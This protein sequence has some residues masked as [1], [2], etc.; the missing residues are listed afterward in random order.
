LQGKKVMVLAPE[1]DVALPGVQHRLMPASPEAFARELYAA[2]REA[3]DAHADVALVVPPPQSGLGI[4]VADRLRKAA[5]PR[6]S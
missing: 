6:D 3:D 1:C 4:A 5:A 2:L